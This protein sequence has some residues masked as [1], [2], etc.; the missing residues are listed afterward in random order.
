MLW[1]PTGSFYITYDMT[2]EAKQTF[3]DDE[4]TPAQTTLL[5]YPSDND[6]NA[7]ILKHI[8]SLF[9]NMLH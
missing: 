7:H 4:W 2:F 1:I 5:R 9:L 8:I 6:D 3:R